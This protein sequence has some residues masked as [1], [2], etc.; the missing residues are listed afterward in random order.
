MVKEEFRQEHIEAAMTG[1]S[2]GLQTEIS[3]FVCLDKECSY[4]TP[5][6]NPQRNLVF[7]MMENHGWQKDEAEWSML[8]IQS[9]VLP[10][11]CSMKQFNSFKLEWDQFS[12]KVWS[13][14]KEEHELE[15]KNQLTFRLN[16][17]LLACVPA[18]VEKEIYEV[19]YGG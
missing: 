18:P 16:Y 13:R 15:D 10:S 2:S 12:E 3:Q 19:L 7:H 1:V 4:V 14:Y 5:A 9:P 17:Q 8:E 6:L 11:G